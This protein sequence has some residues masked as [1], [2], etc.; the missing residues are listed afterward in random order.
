VLQLKAR[1][2]VLTQRQQ[3]KYAALDC[4]KI[5]AEQMPA[6]LTLQ[7][8]SFADGQKLVLSGICSPDQLGQILGQGKFYDAVRKAKL[9]GQDMFEPVAV[10]PLGYN[11]SA[12]AV[13]WHF[14]L[15]LKH[16]EAVP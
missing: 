11:Q 13:N 2:A 15:Q 8:S 3:L 6:G 4:W 7:R 9:N 5:V 16:S 14:T 10:E 12:S 1:Y